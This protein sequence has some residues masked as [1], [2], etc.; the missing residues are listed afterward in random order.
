MK[1]L[2]QNPE[3]TEQ[4]LRDAGFLVSLMGEGFVVSLENRRISRAEVAAVLACET[5]DIEMVSGGVLV[6]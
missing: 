4:T 5:D 1:Q 3:E 6:R 2:I